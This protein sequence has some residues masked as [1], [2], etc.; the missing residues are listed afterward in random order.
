MSGSVGWVPCLDIGRDENVKTN[1]HL[2]SAASFSTHPA[3]S[4]R[5]ASS[6]DTRSVSAA[7]TAAET[8][9]PEAGASPGGAPL[10][11]KGRDLLF[12]FRQNIHW[13]ELL[14]I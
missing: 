12:W 5:F 11:V 4:T 8:S 10:I 13:R 14:L 6:S 9:S 1:T 3:P 7:A 2:G